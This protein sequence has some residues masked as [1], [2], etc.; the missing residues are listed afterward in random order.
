VA[1]RLTG[2][3]RERHP[4]GVQTLSVRRM[5][6]IPA[7]LTPDRQARSDAR[8]ELS[9]VLE[10]RVAPGVPRVDVRVRVDNPA[11]DHRLR[12]LF[13]T[14]APVSHCDAATTFDVARRSTAPRDGSDWIH[15]APATFPQQGFVSAGGLSVTAP[16]LLEAEV[17][18][19]GVIVL[20]LLRATGWL[21]RPDLKSRQ[22]EAGPSL[23]TPGAQASG[24]TEA[25]VALHA[26][27]D[28]AMSTDAELG[29][30]ATVAGSDAPMPPAASLLEVSPSSVLLSALK[31]AED[32]EDVVLRLLN[33][34]DEP[35]SAR[36]AL[37]AEIAAQ[38][39]GVEAIRLDETPAPDSVQFDGRT[40]ELVT[41]AHALRSLRLRSRH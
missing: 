11:N 13:P 18:A 3:S 21:S 41:P 24:R 25:F 37:S 26:G 4:S 6:E 8:V 16:G 20:T 7:C 28:P 39:D 5:L 17:S 32:G 12:L 34:T 2:V 14:G 19:Q 9:L 38:I 33:P 40:I 22:G 30:R 23:L 1:E 29:L 27:L 35:Q 10:V 15:P 31:P 36:V